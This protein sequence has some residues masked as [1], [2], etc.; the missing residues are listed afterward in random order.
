[1]AF[2]ELNGWSVPVASCELS[3]VGI[4]ES[5]GYSPNGIYQMRRN[6]F[7]R[8]WRC[9]SGLL[10][11][12][13]RDALLEML[14]HRGDG[15]NWDLRGDAPAGVH[16]S[17]KHF[18]S[19]KFRP[20]LSAQ[21]QA[22]VESAYAA[23]R[24]RVYDWNAN[25]LAAHERCQG[26]LHVDPAS[27]NLLSATKAHPTANGHLVDVS[28]GSHAADSSRYWTGSGAVEVT[29]GGVGGGVKASSF[30]TIGLT[31]QLSCYVSPRAGGESL[32]VEYINGGASVLGTANYTLLGDVDTWQRLVV[33]GVQATD[34]I[35]NIQVTSQSGSPVFGIDGLQI[36]QV[37]SG[38]TAWLDPAAD[39]WGSGLGVRPAGRLDFDQWTTGFLSGITLSAWVNIQRPGVTGTLV[40]SAATGTAVLQ[41]TGGQYNCHIAATDGSLVTA[42][43]GTTEVGP[44]NIV[45]VY[46]PVTATVSLYV[47]G[48]FIASDSVWSGARERWDVDQATGDFAIGT[49]GNPGVNVSP[50]PISSLLVLPYVVPPSAIESWYRAGTDARP[51]VGV[52]PI[53]ATGSFLQ[54]GNEEVMVLG[55]VDGTPHEPYFT[56]PTLE[57]RGGRVA[58]TLFEA[59]KR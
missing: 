18:Y 16:Y 28:T 56:G 20:A 31:Y 50:G 51:T 14:G 52:M 41:V 9:R 42:L 12:G 58:F 24:A 10:T 49:N 34:T 39:I 57:E 43:G 32:T 29:T 21:Q 59:E 53:H 55:Q 47:D 26:V 25:R 3:Q 44:H 45:G 37:D 54:Q 15:W 46:D 40:R 48:I 7:A 11:S 17:D 33:F 4:A 22:T 38:P 27:T 2:M 8:A 36:E 13:E 6:S 30:A 19:N 23:D 1:M 35:A 5:R